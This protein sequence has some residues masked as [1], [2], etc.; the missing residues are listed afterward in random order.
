MTPEQLDELDNAEVATV[1]RNDRL[2]ELDRDGRIGHDLAPKY[3][4][5]RNPLI[6]G[7]EVLDLGLARG[8]LGRDVVVA[9]AE[10]LA[11]LEVLIPECIFPVR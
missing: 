1:D 6:A 8:D 2:V 4:A 11:C 9:V 7:P 3:V 5:A 10:S